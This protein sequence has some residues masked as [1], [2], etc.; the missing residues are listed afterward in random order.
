MRGIS[1]TALVISNVAYW[2]I[3]VLAVA[4]VTVVAF[5][6]VLFADPNA[7]SQSVE[8]LKSSNDF[9]LLSSLVAR[10][11]A[12]IG[13]GFVAARL[14]RER[15][16]LQSALAL[17]AST[18]LYVFDLGHGPQLDDRAELSD[19]PG[20]TLATVY[21]FAGPMLGVLGGFLAILRD[22]RLAALSPEQR[23]ARTWLAFL[24]AVLRWIL[25]FSAATVTLG[26]GVMLMIAVSSFLTACV[27]CVATVTA[28]LVG[29]LVAPPAQRRLAGFL[30]IGLT[31]LIPLEQIVRHAWSDGPTNTDAVLIVTNAIAAG[32]AYVGLRN[33]FPLA[34]TSPPGRWWWVL[35]LDLARWS[36]D[37]RTVRR[38]LTVTFIII[39]FALLLFM[40]GFFGGHGLG[41]VLA[42]A[43]AAVTTLPVA[44]MAARPT[45]ARVA[46]DLL[47]RADQNAAARH[48][49]HGPTPA[50]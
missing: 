15:P 16:L 12:A 30:F 43:L 33:A 47:S 39:W 17:S 28:I 40:W 29:T 50:E 26:V 25:A 22:A 37:E 20:S 23:S 3:L 19:S 4:V 8:A 42:L 9:G 34:F 31:L 2:A 32:F 21:L 35:D 41:Q 46:P 13:G 1:L 10:T 18:L 49:A 7:L 14:N 11:A 27:L 6:I 36:P 45:F 48:E 44:L 5:I 24:V 38:G